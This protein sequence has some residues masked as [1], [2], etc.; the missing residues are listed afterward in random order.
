MNFLHAAAVGQQGHGLAHGCLGEGKVRGLDAAAFTVDFSHR[1]GGVELH[2][3]DVAAVHHLHTALATGFHALEHFVF[4][5]QVP[6][7][8]VF[9]GLQHGACGRRGVAAALD[10]DAVEEGAVGLVVVGVDF[11]AHHVARLEVDELVGPGAHRLEVGRRLA[12]LGARVGAKWC[13]GRI[14]PSAATKAVAQK[15]VALGKATSTVCESTL[16]TVTSL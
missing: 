10:L 8:V 1:V 4:H 13:L 11:T 6:G 14:M 12:R 9:A 15:G 2:E 3:F 5:L 7:V 16:V